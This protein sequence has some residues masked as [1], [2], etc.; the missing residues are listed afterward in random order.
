MKKANGFQFK[1]FVIAQDRCA[2][3]VNTDGILLGCI[4]DVEDCEHILDIGTGTGLI[5]LMLAQRSTKT[6]AKIIGLEIEPNAYAQSIENVQNCAWHPRIQIEH[7]DLLKFKPTQKFD[8]IVS[9]PPYFEHSLASRSNERDLARSITQEHT[10][11]H[12]QW[13][14]KASELLTEQGKI[15]F[16]LPVDM[17]QKL[18]KQ[19]PDCNLYCCETWEITTKQTKAPKRMVVTFAKQNFCKK[20]QKNDRFFITIYDENNQY[21]EQ[22]KLL[23]KDFYLAF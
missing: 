9:N 14:Q 8:L 5:T 4:A 7:Q 6:Q 2:M 13:L 12:F 1:Q 23:T 15:S 18:M 10:Q 3:K 11:S 17:A 19:A 21:T 20:P 16:I 22:F